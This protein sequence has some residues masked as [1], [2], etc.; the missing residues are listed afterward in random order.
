MIPRQKFPK[1]YEKDPSKINPLKIL[2]FEYFCFY[3][4]KSLKSP[5]L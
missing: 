5:R 1:I 4:K 2:Q 3:E